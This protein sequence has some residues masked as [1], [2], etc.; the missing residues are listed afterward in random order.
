M[1]REL[2]K[3]KRYAIVECPGP[4]LFR[5]ENREGLYADKVSHIE[6]TPNQAMYLQDMLEEYKDFPKGKKR[7]A[8]LEGIVSFEEICDKDF[9]NEEAE[10]YPG[11]EENN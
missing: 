5:I 4:G 3:T 6:I 9:E 8:K 2:A 11:D 1:Y 7:E 10:L